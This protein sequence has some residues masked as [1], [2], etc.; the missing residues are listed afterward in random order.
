MKPFYAAGMK[1][2]FF[3]LWAI[4]FIHLEKLMSGR[5]IRI[6]SI[7]ENLDFPYANCET[8]NMTLITTE[9]RNGLE[10][11]HFAIVIPESI[12]TQFKNADA[13]VDRRIS[14]A[15]LKATGVK[16]SPERGS[17]PVYHL[18]GCVKVLDK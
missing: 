17:L 2:S 10:A 6:N 14:F 7:Q 16:T 11:D 15:F 18:G 4:E 3:L 13:L 12:S 1:A 8:R 5:I 9:A